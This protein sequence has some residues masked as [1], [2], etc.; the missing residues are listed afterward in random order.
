MKFPSHFIH[1]LV[2]GFEFPSGLVIGITGIQCYTQEVREEG[3]F[4]QN[5]NLRMHLGSLRFVGSSPPLMARLD[6]CSTDVS[7]TSCFRTWM[8][9]TMLIATP[10]QCECHDRDPWEIQSGLRLI[11]HPTASIF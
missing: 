10:D 4:V 2:D 11:H 7:S 6:G 9:H 8:N 5:A 3:V 1:E